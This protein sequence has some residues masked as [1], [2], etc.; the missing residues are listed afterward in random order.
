MLELSSKNDF[1]VIASNSTAP[2]RIS[3]ANDTNFLS[4]VAFQVCWSFLRPELHEI[5]N[6]KYQ[7][8][9]SI[10]SPALTR[11]FSAWYHR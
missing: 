6:L 2:G 11:V 5:S 4:A 9:I 10:F 8:F 1:I 3:K 7:N